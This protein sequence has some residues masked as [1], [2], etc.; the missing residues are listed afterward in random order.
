MQTNPFKPPNSAGEVIESNVLFPK[1][2][3]ILFG[4][5]LLIA[6]FAL[7]DFCFDYS[8]EQS[9]IIY[10]HRPFHFTE[11]LDPLICKCFLVFLVF[12]TFLIIKTTRIA[13][14]K[15]RNQCDD[16]VPSSK[17]AESE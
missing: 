2:L 16:R 4:F 14:D 7:L 8:R 11:H 9:V 10:T 13:K 15:S 12:I 1:T 3:A 17:S 5:G 6:S